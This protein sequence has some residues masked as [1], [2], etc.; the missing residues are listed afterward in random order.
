MAEQSATNSDCP[1]TIP[2]PAWVNSSN[3]VSRVMWLAKALLIGELEID[4]T[5]SGTGLLDKILQM[6][7]LDWRNL[8]RQELSYQRDAL[9]E[10]YARSC[11]RTAGQNLEIMP[12]WETMSSVLPSVKFH[13]A[14][15]TER[16]C[17]RSVVSPWNVLSI[18]PTP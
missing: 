9:L 13:L 14:K 17:Q 2:G 12:L 18:I 16:N 15:I 1:A 8:E 5:V 4:A 10:A 3:A 6:L 11:G 7:R